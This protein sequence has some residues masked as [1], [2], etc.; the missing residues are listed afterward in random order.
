MEIRL[1]DFFNA[2]IDKEEI[3]K[4]AIVDKWLSDCDGFTNSGDI[5]SK[6]HFIKRNT[7]IIMQA[8]LN[9]NIKGICSRC[10]EEAVIPIDTEMTIMFI[11][12]NQQRKYLEDEVVEITSDE[13][14]VEYY[15]GNSIEVDYLFRESL[16]LAIPFS[17]LCNESCKGLCPNCGGNLNRGECVCHKGNGIF[18]NIKINSLF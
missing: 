4:P 11:P 5:L 7:N 8:S 9:G 18:N 15:K 6:A 16:L 14:D 12:A 13:L 10:L 17:P 2:Q 3:F 1:E